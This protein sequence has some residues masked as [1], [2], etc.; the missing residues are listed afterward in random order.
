MKRIGKIICAAFVAATIGCGGSHDHDHDH[1][2]DHDHD[3]GEAGH[4]HDEGGGHAHQPKYGGTPVELGEHQYHVEL[5]RDGEAGKMQ[6]W[7]L[8]GHLENF[9]RVKT[10]SFEIKASVGDKTETLTFLATPNSAT[11]ETVGDTSYFEA[12]AD[13]LK[14]TGEFGGEIVS[15]EIRGSS[16]TGVKFDYPK[17]NE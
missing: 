7:I 17:G 15:L 5:L 1:A 11:G 13:W 2:H 3:H 14:A 8:D 4:T 9:I 16:F 6:L 12:Q 10:D